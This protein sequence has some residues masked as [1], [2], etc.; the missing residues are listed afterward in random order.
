MPL[1]VLDLGH[2]V[3]LLASLSAFGNAIISPTSMFDVYRLYS[4]VIPT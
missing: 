4:Q 1:V 3:P 2:I